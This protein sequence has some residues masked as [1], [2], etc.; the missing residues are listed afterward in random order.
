MF[1]SLAK[2]NAFELHKL[3]LHRLKKDSKVSY[4]ILVLL[5]ATIS[6]TLTL[7][8]HLKIFFEVVPEEIE[9]GC[10][11]LYIGTTSKNMFK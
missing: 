9:V 3:V 11:N 2:L 5:Q 10:T 8:C 6:T 1:S 4:S 7:F